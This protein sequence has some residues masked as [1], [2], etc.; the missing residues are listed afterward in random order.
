MTLWYEITIQKSFIKLNTYLLFIKDAGG[1]LQDSSNVSRCEFDHAF[2]L[3][4][5]LSNNS[6][7][8]Y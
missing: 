2:D 3:G 1:I 6:R 8:P 5:S 7:Y 4:Y